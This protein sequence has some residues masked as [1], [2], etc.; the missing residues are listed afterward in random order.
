MQLFV[1]YVVV[2]LASTSIVIHP[3]LHRCHHNRGWFTECEHVIEWVNKFFLQ[4]TTSPRKTPMQENV[5][6]TLYS[7]HLSFL[8]HVTKSRF[9]RISILESLLYCSFS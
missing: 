6:L 1:C 4:S 3:S 7:F 8:S 5:F 9:P 2:L